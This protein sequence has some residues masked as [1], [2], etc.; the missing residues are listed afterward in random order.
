MQRE[1]N[2]NWQEVRAE[3]FDA[4]VDYDTILIKKAWVKFV[5]IES[6]LLSDY[7]NIL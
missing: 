4:I 2:F 1:I 6:K 5:I 7:D 3:I